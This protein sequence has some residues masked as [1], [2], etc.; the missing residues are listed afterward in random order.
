MDIDN[1][2]AYNDCYGH[3]AGDEALIKVSRALSNCFQRTGD[4]LFRLGGEEFGAILNVDSRA[5][6]EQALARVHRCVAELELPHE[7]NP[8]YGVLTLSVGAYLETEYRKKRTE[9]AIYLLA[10][11]ALYEAK[12]EGRSR[13]VLKVNGLT[14]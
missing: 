12:H 6:A 3:Q 13:S 10:D 1:F 2:K 14:D 11:K 8:P 7:K 5:A 9:T 4:C